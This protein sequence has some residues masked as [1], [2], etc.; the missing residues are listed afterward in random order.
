M[1]RGKAEVRCEEGGFLLISFYY[2]KF[3]LKYAFCKQISGKYIGG[4]C[5]GIVVFPEGLPVMTE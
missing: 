5:G 2:F 3:Y 4:D 1:A